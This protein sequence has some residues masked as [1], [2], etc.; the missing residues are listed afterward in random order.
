MEDTIMI[1]EK[2]GTREAAIYAEHCIRAG[3]TCNDEQYSDEEC[4]DLL[5]LD[6]DTA[7]AWAS[8]NR[9]T[10]DG[11]FFRRAG[12][13]A[14]RELDMAPYDGDGWGHIESQEVAPGEHVQPD[15]WYRC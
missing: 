1:R 8:D 3:Q 2:R 4:D 10:P 6:A 13:N 5:W 14:L 9:A 11:A 7:R 12:K 15:E